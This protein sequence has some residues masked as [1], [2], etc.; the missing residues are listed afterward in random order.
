MKSESKLINKNST[1]LVRIEA[2]IHKLLKVEAA[3]SQMT[4]RDLLEGYLSELL[5]VERSNMKIE[6]GD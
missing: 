5:S 2:S 4:I 6:G 1:K 3:K